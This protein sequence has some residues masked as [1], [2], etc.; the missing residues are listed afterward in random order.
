VAH[1]AAGATLHI[2]LADRDSAW[3][4]F[5]PIVPDHGKMM[6]AFLIRQPDGDAFAHVHPTA[7]DADTFRA[8]LP[9]LPSGTY[10]LYADVVHESGFAQTLTDTLELAT[11]G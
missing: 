9:A 2:V 7:I 4:P 5:S 1:D 11:D 10:V 6:H 3:A 8:P